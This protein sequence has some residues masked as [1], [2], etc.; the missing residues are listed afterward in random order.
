MLV[1]LANEPQAIMRELVRHDFLSRVHVGLVA[2]M[3]ASTASAAAV[4]DWHAQRLTRPAGG[5]VR[6]LRLAETI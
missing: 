1:T 6:T 4:G 5:V 3:P 2:A